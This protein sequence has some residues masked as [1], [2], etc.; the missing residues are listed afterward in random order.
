MATDKL[1]T[2][3][4]DSMVKLSDS[5][6]KTVDLVE[7]GNYPEASKEYGANFVPVMKKLY[8]EAAEIYPPRFSKVDEWCKWT[9]RVYIFTRR[10][11]ETLE[12]AA[13]AGSAEPEQAMKYLMALREYFYFL[14]D[15]SEYLRSSDFIYAFHKELLDEQP[16][17]ARLRSLIEALEEAEPSM[18]AAADADA[19]GAV[20]KEWAGK[21]TPLL[22]GGAPEGDALTQLRD[23]TK[24]FYR[25]Y[26][27]QF[28]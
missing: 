9:K 22:D 25:Q 8:S 3:W 20:R 15:D 14:H 18:N 4:D 27:I 19:Y 24:P 5:Y 11:E 21:V 7:A 6:A 26:G 10:T 12:A 28:E 1:N 13:E 16:D 17:A 2:L 23:A